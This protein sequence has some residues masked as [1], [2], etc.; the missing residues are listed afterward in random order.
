MGVNA[1]GRVQC[2]WAATCMQVTSE[3]GSG[4]GE[5]IKQQ[6]CSLHS[7]ATWKLYGKFN[8]VRSEAAAAEQVSRASH[9]NMC[10][11]ATSEGETAH[12][13]KP[14]VPAPHFQRFTAANQDF[15][16]Q[17]GLDSRRA[18]KSLKTAALSSSRRTHTRAFFQA[19]ECLLL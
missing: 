17:A 2:T 10:S 12:F 1:R 9:G 19:T 3:N 11:R 16:V 4:R 5:E 14:N 7:W 6:L 18:C 8:F 15:A 13:C